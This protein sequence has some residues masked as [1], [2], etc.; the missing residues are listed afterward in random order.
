[1]SPLPGFSGSVHDSVTDVPVTAAAVTRVG[2]PGGAGAAVVALA[3]AEVALT[4]SPLMALT[5]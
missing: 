5:R 3:V 2:G 4:P 1:M